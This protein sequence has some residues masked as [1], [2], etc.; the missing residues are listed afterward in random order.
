MLS[1]K[2][3]T[4]NIQYFCCYYWLFFNFPS[5]LSL[6]YFIK[7]RLNTYSTLGTRGLISLL[8][9]SSN[10]EGTEQY[11]EMLPCLF[12]ASCESLLN[13]AIP[14]M[15]VQHMIAKDIG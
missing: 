12:G 11:I 4:T 2:A 8:N 6:P 15:Y 1:L 3:P 9:Y 14:W 13:D 10:F 7:L 5:S